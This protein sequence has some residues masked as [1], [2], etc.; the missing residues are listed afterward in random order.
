MMLE[1]QLNTFFSFFLSHLGSQKEW[2]GVANDFDRVRVWCII[3]SFFI[4]NK[5]I[6]VEVL[7]PD[8]EISFVGDKDFPYE[9]WPDEINKGHV[10]CAECPTDEVCGMCDHFERRLRLFAL[11]VNYEALRKRAVESRDAEALLGMLWVVSEKYEGSA[12]EIINDLFEMGEIDLLVGQLGEMVGGGYCGAAVDKYS[13]GDEPDLVKE[14]GRMKGLIYDLILENMQAF[15]LK[16]VAMLFVAKYSDDTEK[17]YFAINH[18]IF[19]KAWEEIAVLREGA[20]DPQIQLKAAQILEDYIEEIHTPRAI[21]TVMKFGVGEE[22]WDAAVQIY[23][24]LPRTDTFS[25]DRLSRVPADFEG[26][27]D[28][29]PFADADASEA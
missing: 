16:P 5:F 12:S 14:F 7:D 25:T 11:S 18:L 20:R 27:I 23:N 26:K 4:I 8:R 1:N 29:G 15:S 19:T 9:G 21:G 6:M 10:A 3:G 2:S 17:V 13:L 24:A 22:A 28:Y